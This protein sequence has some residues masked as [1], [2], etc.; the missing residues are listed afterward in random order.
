MEDVLGDRCI[1]I[2]LEKSTSNK[3]KLVERWT[4]EKAYQ[5]IVTTL[6]SFI[7]CS[8]CRCSYENNIIEDWNNYITTLTTDTTITTLT[9]HSTLKK[10]YETGINGRYLELGF[11]LFVVGSLLGKEIFENILKIYSEIVNQ[12]KD[13]NLTENSDIS[14]YDMISQE[15]ESNY[16]IRVKDL[17]DKFRQFLQSNEEWLNDKWMGRALKRLNLILESKRMSSGVQVKLNYK[18]AQEQLN[19]FK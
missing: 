10:I 7:Q 15:Q 1:P 19:K 9:T 13:D 11:P 16:F 6:T 8:L 17:T 5:D 4:H 3:T 18:K 14:L 12:K 2:I